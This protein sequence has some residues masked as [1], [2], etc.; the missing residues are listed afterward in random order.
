[1]RV[2]Q[3][4]VGAPAGLGERVLV[5]VVVP[6]HNEAAGLEFS[7]R[8]LHTYLGGRFPF[9]RR[10]TVADNGSTDGTGALAERLPA[11]QAWRASSCD[12]ELFAG[13]CSSPEGSGGRQDPSRGGGRPYRRPGGARRRVG[14]RYRRRTG[15]SGR[16]PAGIRRTGAHRP[17]SC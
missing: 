6:V 13:R 8:R 9:A 15:G 7:V 17:A 1:M 10:I 11:E 16:P 2:E 5:D 3:D 14:H 12:D 4:L